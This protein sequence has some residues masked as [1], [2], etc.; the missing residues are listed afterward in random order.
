MELKDNPLLKQEDYLEG[1]NENIQNLRNRPE[2]IEYD[3]ITHDCFSTPQG[4]KFI[5]A[6][7]KRYLMP[8]LVNRAAANY[9]LMVIWADGYKD[10]YRDIKFHIM[11][12]EQ[13]IKAGSSV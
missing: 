5:E 9:Q 2:L 4:K 1:Y 6:T 3:K 8:S 7:E 12:H 11:S 13:R 10:A